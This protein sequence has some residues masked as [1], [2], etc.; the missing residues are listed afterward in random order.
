MDK[1]LSIGYSTCPNDTFIF[2]ALINGKF[3]TKGLRF[4]PTLADVEELN[5]KA[6]DE[7]LDITKLSMFAYSQV[8][9]KYQILDSGSALGNK[10]GPLIIS[11]KKISISQLE[12]YKI[13]IPGIHTTANFLLTALFPKVKNKVEI[14]FSDIESAI[15]KGEVDAGVIIHETRFT[16]HEHGFMKLVDL[17]Q[18]WELKTGLPIPLGCIA[19]KRSIPDDIKVKVNSLL[20]KSIEQAF[21][22]PN[23]AL[24]YCKLHAQEMEEEIMLKHIEL[25]VNDYSLSLGEEGRNAIATLFE[26]A[27]SLNLL[28]VEPQNIF[29]IVEG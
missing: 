11:K 23:A 22:N 10:N 28:E 8:S 6:F 7:S 19:I 5:K 26:I 25:Y 27:V 1:N 18:R 29:S 17:G 12:N 2:D 3:D 20:K 9:D 15:E 4:T 21:L 24:N 13:A 16:Y 14:L